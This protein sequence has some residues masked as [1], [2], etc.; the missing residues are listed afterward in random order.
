MHGAA[1]EAALQRGIDLR[2]AEGE[3]AGVLAKRRRAARIEV[4]DR[5]P[6]MAKRVARERRKPFHTYVLYLFLLIP[7]L[8]AGVK[9]RDGGSSKS[10]VVAQYMK[11]PPHLS[12][13]PMERKT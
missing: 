8:D 11:P 5:P 1:G 4:C 3:Q 12:P 6:K 13:P 10:P 2:Q 7:R 9:D